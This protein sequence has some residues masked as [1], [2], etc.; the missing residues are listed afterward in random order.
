LRV[1]LRDFHPIELDLVHA[2][3]Q[4][5]RGV[6]PFAGEDGEIGSANADVTGDAFH[7]G[8]TAIIKVRYSP[9]APVPASPPMRKPTNKTGAFT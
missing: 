8:R 2:P 7:L 6:R 1:G 3:I 4:Q 9:A 5:L